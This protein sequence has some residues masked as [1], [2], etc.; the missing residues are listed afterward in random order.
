MEGWGGGLCGVGTALMLCYIIWEMVKEKTGI[1]P[2]LFLGIPAFLIL[3]VG[4]LML[5]A[6]K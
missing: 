4:I 2:T 3:I 1:K 6:V 5:I